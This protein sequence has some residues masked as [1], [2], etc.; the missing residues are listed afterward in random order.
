MTHNLPITI[1]T[2]PGGITAWLVE[3]RMVPVVSLQ[4]AFRG[5]SA[6]DPAD[7][8]G[9][10]NLAAS[11]LDEGAGDLPAM[12]FH[13][14]LED[15]SIYLSFSAR[16]DDFHG[17]VKTLHDNA[18]EA[19]RLLT[20]AL[21]QPRF[22]N[23][24]VSRVKE[25]LISDIQHHYADPSWVAQRTLNKMIYAGHPYQQPTSGFEETVAL[26]TSD[27]LRTWVKERM[28]RD[29]LIV[30]VCGDISAADLASLLDQ[31]FGALPAKSKPFELPKV[32]LAATGENFT[33]MRSIPQ[34]RVVMAQSG[35]SRSDS[36]WF[37]AMV[38][39]YVLG[40]GGF[41]SRL[42]MEVREKRGL[43]YGVSSQLSHHKYS[44]ILSVGAA[45]SNENAAEAIR[46]IKSEWQ[47]MANDGISAEE[48]KNAQT[49]LTGSLPLALT[50]TDKI[51]D[52]I[53]HLQTEHLG[54]DYPARRLEKLNAV[55]RADVAQVAKRLLNPEA[56]TLVA[57]GQPQNLINSIA[58]PD[59]AQ[60]NHYHG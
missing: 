3:D 32:T 51:A 58:A 40:G 18:G 13:G 38:M 57:V 5:G 19:W 35:I 15:Q 28:A 53:L 4:F 50:S 29:N 2:S 7:K 37:A 10:A 39:N 6:L 26:L 23:E 59:P 41:N 44:N 31:I 55:T 48:L 52:F 30:G 11:T 20:L 43:T 25:Q 34:T 56:L 12:A 42:M 22:D 49:Y 36:D 17:G 60:G 24:E 14:A 8:V 47:T 54:I 21:T 27:D 46:I 9:L 33:V 45:T 16:R 1:V